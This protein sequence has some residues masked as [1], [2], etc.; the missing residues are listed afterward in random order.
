V[1]KKGLYFDAAEWFY[2]R[3]NKTPEEISKILPVCANT[4]YQWSADGHWAVKRQAALGSPRGIADKLRRLAEQKV[5][6]LEVETLDAAACD[7]LYKLLSAIQ[8]MEQLEDMRVLGIAVM[9]NFTRFLKIQADPEV[10]MLVG[11]WV[12]AWFQSLE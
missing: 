11:K 1:S 6:D 8:K 12:R 5:A 9:D 2:I 7:G 3:A 4:I 10:V